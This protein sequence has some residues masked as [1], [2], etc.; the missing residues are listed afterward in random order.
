MPWCSWPTQKELSGIFVDVLSHFA[1]SIFQ[2]VLL[3][4]FLS[5]F[6]VLCF[7]GGMLFLFVVVVLF[8]YFFEREEKEHKN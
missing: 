4:F 6:L 8:L 5:S 2:N 7:C 3:V 1:L